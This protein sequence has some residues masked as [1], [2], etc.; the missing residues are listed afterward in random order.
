MDGHSSFLGM[1]RVWMS[2]T[3]GNEIQRQTVSKKRV[4]KVP[5]P[6]YRAIVLSL[7]GIGLVA[8]GFAAGA[9]I[10][11]AQNNTNSKSTIDFSAIPAKVRIEAP[12]L[13]LTDIHGNSHALSDYRGQVVL[14]NLWATWCPPCQA[15]MPELQDFYTNHQ[16]QGFTLIGIEDG[17]PTADVISFV[18]KYGLNFS[19]WLDPNYLASHYAFRTMNLPSSYVIDRYGVIRLEWMGAISEQ[20]LEKSIEPIVQE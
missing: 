4:V 10:L 17:D 3:A 20:N 7:L 9:L 18:H 11:T 13:T 14:V 16:N 5:Q 8:T 19:I 1:T 2:Y 15:E 12:A 6:A